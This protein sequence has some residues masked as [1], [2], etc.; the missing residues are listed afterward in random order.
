MANRDGACGKDDVIAIGPQGGP[1]PGGRDAASAR[2]IRSWAVVAHCPLS[3]RSRSARRRR[4]PS[5]D[6]RMPA[7]R[8]RAWTIGLWARSTA[9]LP[10]P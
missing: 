2:G 7:W 3:Q 1:R 4:A 9:P 5:A 8:K 6:H 10:I